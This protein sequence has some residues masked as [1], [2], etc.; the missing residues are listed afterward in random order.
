MNFKGDTI[1]GKYRIKGDYTEHLET[2]KWGAKLTLNNPIFKNK[3]FSIMKLN[4]RNGLGEILFH[5]ILTTNYRLEDIVIN[6]NSKG[7]FTIEEHFSKQYLKIRGLPIGPI[8]KIDEKNLWKARITILICI[9][10]RK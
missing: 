7:Y 6:G 3:K 8:L 4:S 1:K 9:K 10:N 5:E 2:D